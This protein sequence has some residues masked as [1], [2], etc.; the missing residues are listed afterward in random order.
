[1]DTKTYRAAR[2]SRQGLAFTQAWYDSR[3]PPPRPLGEVSCA[4]ASARGLSGR[5][6]ADQEGAMPLN[7]VSVDEGFHGESPAATPPYRMEITTEGLFASS[8]F[9]AFPPMDGHPST[10]HG[11][12]S[13]PPC[14]TSPRDEIFAKTDRRSPKEPHRSNWADT[15]ISVT[16]RKKNVIYGVRASHCRSESDQ[17]LKRARQR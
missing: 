13:V 9:L 8:L 15:E 11:Y 16:S 1:M 14:C 10:V 7:R 4:L 12:A 6:I 3:G 17:G 2:I 5:W